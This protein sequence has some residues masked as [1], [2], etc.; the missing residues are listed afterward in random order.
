MTGNREDAEDL[1]QETF[2]RVLA[3]PRLVRGGSDQRYLLRALR[4]TYFDTRRTAA[5]RPSTDELP[6]E[7][8]LIDHSQHDP[9]DRLARHEALFSAIAGLADD[10]RDA[11]VAVD[12]VGLS[13]REAASALHTREETLATRLFRARQQVA[14]HIASHAPEQAPSPQRRPDRVRA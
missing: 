6:D 14:R 10:H 11:L 9:A 8:S 3:R 7:A 2:A 5:R 4:N 13:Y 1:V 12:I